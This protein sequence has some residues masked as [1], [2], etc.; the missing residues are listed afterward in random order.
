M[1]RVL[2]IRSVVRA[3]SAFVHGFELESISEGIN[4]HKPAM[5]LVHRDWH[6]LYF[7]N[8][9]KGF[10]EDNYFELAEKRFKE[11]GIVNP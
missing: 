9:R 10:T 8:E 2:R 4:E 5:I 1:A 3:N 6:E 11:L 7:L